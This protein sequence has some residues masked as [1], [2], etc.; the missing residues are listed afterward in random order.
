MVARIAAGRASSDIIKAKVPGLAPRARWKSA[1]SG[2][3]LLR[4][5]TPST[6]NR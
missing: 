5:A 2:I 3:I 1:A 6:P 4:Q